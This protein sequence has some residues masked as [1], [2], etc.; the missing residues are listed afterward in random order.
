MLKC[1]VCEHEFSPVKNNH[2]ISRDKE[3]IGGMVTA[4]SKS[5]PCEYDTFDCPVCGCQVIAQE[6]KKLD[7]PYSHF[8]A[9]KVKASIMNISIDEA[10]AIADGYETE[11]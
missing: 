8:L 11:E 10:L 9:E 4:I 7:A 1:K 2:Y 3:V 6:R 5:E